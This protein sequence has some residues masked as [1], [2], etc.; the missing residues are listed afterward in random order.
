MERLLNSIFTKH[1]LTPHAFFFSVNTFAVTAK[2]FRKIINQ[3]IIVKDE[4]QLRWVYQGSHQ[5]LLRTFLWNPTWRGRRLNCVPFKILM[6]TSKLSV[7][8]NLTLGDRVFKKVIKFKF[9]DPQSNR[10]EMHIKREK[11]ACRYKTEGN[12]TQMGR[13][14][15]VQVKERRL[16]RNQPWSL[17][18]SFQNCE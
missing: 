10:T 12:D 6:L 17:T 2:T 13:K 8:Q 15:Y 5:F 4:V 9:G 1:I 7:P 11:C 16:R 14:S 18:C 3:Q